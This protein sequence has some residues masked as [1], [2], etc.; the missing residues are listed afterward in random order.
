MSSI[1]INMKDL[2]KEICEEY[3]SRGIEPWCWC[4]DTDESV[5]YAISCGALL[6]T[7]NAPLAKLRAKQIKNA[8]R[9]V[10]F[11]VLPTG[12]SD[13]FLNLGTLTDSASE[14]VELCAADFTAADNVYFFDMRRVD[15][16]SFF[17]TAA[18]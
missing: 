16:E 1:G 12:H 5:E 4:P 8:P 7:V 9:S 14:V 3:A 10:F 13:E 6:A 11:F 17:N 2:T 15:G 18:V